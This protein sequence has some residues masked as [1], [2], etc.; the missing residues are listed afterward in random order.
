MKSC[1]MPM[2]TEIG[3][4]CPYLDRDAPLAVYYEFVSI[5]AG[6]SLCLAAVTS[7]R[8][9]AS[10]TAKAT[11]MCRVCMLCIHHLLVSPAVRAV[12]RTDFLVSAR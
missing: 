3:S 6:G 12:R 10:A 8:I 5:I 9:R 1:V 4:P 7:E 2:G 11:L